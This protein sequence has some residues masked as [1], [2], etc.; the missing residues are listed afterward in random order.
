MHAGPPD[1][2]CLRLSRNAG[3][4]A[5]PHPNAEPCDPLDRGPAGNDPNANSRTSPGLDADPGGATSMQPGP[6]R[7]GAII[8]PRRGRTT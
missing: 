4:S 3:P 2:G 8:Q 7:L 5:C 1:A 6:Y